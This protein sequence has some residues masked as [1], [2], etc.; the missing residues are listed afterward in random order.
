[1]KNYFDQIIA[2]EEELELTV[3]AIGIKRYYNRGEEVVKALDG[4]DLQIKKGEFVSIMGPSGSGKTTLFNC[5]GALDKPTEGSLFLDEIDIAELDTDELAWL[6]CRKI[7]YIF[8]SYNIIKVMTTVNNVMLPMIF[9]GV[10]GLMTLSKVI[11]Q[12]VG[13]TG[14][15]GLSPKERFI[16]IDTDTYEIEASMSVDEANNLLELNIPAGDYE[17]IAGFILE[18]AQSIPSIGKRL[19]YG[20]LRMTVTSMEGNKLEKVRIRKRPNLYE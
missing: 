5:I 3:H 9:G 2:Q 7:G 10:S 17:T 11:E 18:T 8:Q 20:D 4:I 1:M 6:R 19:R 13:T 14:E 15:E 12:I 16:T